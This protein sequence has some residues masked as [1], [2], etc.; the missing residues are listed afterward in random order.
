M[1]KGFENSVPFLK[2]ILSYRDK[3][4]YILSWSFTLKM[5]CRLPGTWI[6]LKSAE[7]MSILSENW[8]PFTPP[9]GNV[10]WYTYKYIYIGFFCLFVLFLFLVQSF[11]PLHKMTSFLFLYY[12][13]YF[14][15]GL[16]TVLLST[17]ALSTGEGRELWLHIK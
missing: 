7:V 17:L 3:S 6:L 1:T 5:T 12:F 8:I 4:L 11:N 13:Q 10:Q 9:Q 16:I 15:H 14:L 2:L